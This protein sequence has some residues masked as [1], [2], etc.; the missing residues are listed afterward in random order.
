MSS[1][2]TRDRIVRAAE[3]LFARNGYAA[4]SL[5]EITESAEVNIASVNYHFGSKEKLLAEILDRVVGPLT[6]RRIELLDECE[7]EGTPDLEQVLTAFLLPD[8]EA[9]TTLRSRDR[10]LPRFVSR[11][12]TEGSDLMNELIGRQ[13]AETQRR[14]Y[15]AFAE[16]IPDL[17]PED[18]AWRVYC[19]VGIVVYLFAGVET[20][21]KPVIGVDVGN[22]LTRLLQVAFPIM[23]APPG[24][25]IQPPT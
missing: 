21:G 14:F 20:P 16:A 3:V 12:Y 18:I 23:A 10:D 9:L 13:F 8:L 19:L 24:E 6:A 2:T 11:M 22:D 4:T 1:A 15:A 5:R 25:V 17:T 7:S